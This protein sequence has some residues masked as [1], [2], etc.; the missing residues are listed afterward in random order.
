MLVK[1][2]IMAGLSLALLIIFGIIKFLKPIETNE[3]SEFLLVFFVMFIF[4]VIYYSIRIFMDRKKEL[5]GY[6]IDYVYGLVIYTGISNLINKFLLKNFSYREFMDVVMI[7][8]PFIVII[9]VIL[10]DLIAKLGEL[11]KINQNIEK[12]IKTRDNYIPDIYEAKK[13]DN[14]LNEEELS[15]KLPIEEENSKNILE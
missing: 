15:T 2:I 11:I 4:P 3:F 8:I 14:P 9:I 7:L 6:V 12:Y 13:D 1:N 10:W 5:E